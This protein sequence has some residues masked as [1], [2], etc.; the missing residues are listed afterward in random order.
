[1]IRSM[2]ESL[3]GLKEEETSVE[4]RKDDDTQVQKGGA[5]WIRKNGD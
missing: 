3:E 1:M 4:F 5:G 2:I